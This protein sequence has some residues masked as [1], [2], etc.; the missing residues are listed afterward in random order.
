MAYQ[1][2]SLPYAYDALEPYIDAK[3]MEIHHGKHHAGY[4]AKLNRALEGNNELQNKSVTDLLSD[5]EAL[6][7]AIQST[8]RHNGGGHYNHSIFWP[9]M[10]KGG[11]GNPPKELSEA[12]TK[13]FGS[14][15]SFREKFSQT[16]LSVFGSGWT[17]L[18]FIEGK[19]VIEPTAN[20]DNPV[21]FDRA[22]ILGLDVW[23]HAYYLKYQ[24]RRTEYIAA[25]WSVI[26]WEQVARNLKK[27]EQEA[28]LGSRSR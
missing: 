23:E 12:L 20:Q 14:I 2:P 1:L 17:W 5:L 10:G 27:V 25:W 11:G 9:C 16:A 8:V 3:T 4:V 18:S 13:D 15:T 28:S 19:L 24:N 6:P 7:K 22:P 21:M 26:N